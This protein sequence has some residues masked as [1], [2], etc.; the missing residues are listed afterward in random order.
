[1][2]KHHRSISQ[3]SERT[4]CGVQSVQ[5]SVMEPHHIRKTLNIMQNLKTIQ[6]QHIAAGMIKVDPRMFLFG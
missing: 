6:I 2:R 1:M 4:L 3:Q 5:S